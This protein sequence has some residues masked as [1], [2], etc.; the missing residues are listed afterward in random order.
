ML[1]SEHATMHAIPELLADSAPRSQ[2]S[3]EAAV[4]PIAEEAVE[5]LM[6]RGLPR[7]QA[8]STLVRGFMQI[9]LP[10]LPEILT[11]HIQRVLAATAEHSL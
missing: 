11:K 3:H 7:D 6:T 8:I 1:L 2:L 10:G 5:Y 9:D 4:G